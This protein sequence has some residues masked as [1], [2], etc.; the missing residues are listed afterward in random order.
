MKVQLDQIREVLEPVASDSPDIRQLK[1]KL[2][3]YSNQWQRMIDLGELTGI[4]EYGAQSAGDGL[5]KIPDLKAKMHEFTQSVKEEATR[6]DSAKITEAEAL[7]S[8]VAETLKNAK[9]AEELDA[10]MLALSKSKL[11][12][13]GSNPKL[14]ATSRDL[15]GTLQI[16]GN[17]QE[18]LIAE[19]TGNTQSSCNQLEQISSQLSTTPI[20]PRS[21]VL[22]LLNPQTPGTP[23]SAA[24]K[25]APTG[26][27]LE[28]IRSKLTEFGDSAWILAE[29]HCGSRRGAQKFRQQVFRAQRADDRRFV[30]S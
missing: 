16:V 20:L 5:A 11:P 4:S 29:P 25:S 1:G 7:I 2:Q 9:K 8:R 14:Q 21:T 28:G 17:W 22:R 18:Y 15:Q 6:R 19:E 27:S 24:Q 26:D 13:Y 10:L 30:H 3:Q 23:Q 12:D